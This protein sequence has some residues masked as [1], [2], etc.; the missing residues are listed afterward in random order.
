MSTIN[1]IGSGQ[2]TQL[3]RLF[4]L[5]ELKKAKKGLASVSF[6]AAI[7][8]AQAPSDPTRAADFFGGAA[9][10]DT[11]GDT[12]TTKLE[13]SAEEKFLDFSKLSDV[14]KLKMKE[15]DERKLTEEKLNEMNKVEREAVE[16]AIRE[17]VAETILQQTGKS[18]GGIADLTV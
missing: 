18:I 14:E 10:G 6:P 16:E 17:K 1:A 5:E 9:R 15:L 4:D 12:S 8:G 13:K 7:Q 2:L 11:S 3:D